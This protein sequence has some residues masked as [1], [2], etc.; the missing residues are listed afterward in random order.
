MAEKEYTYEEERKLSSP[1]K[2]GRKGKGF[3][4]RNESIILSLTI[5]IV[6]FTFT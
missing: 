3:P 2:E 1:R 4:L 5:S 6:F